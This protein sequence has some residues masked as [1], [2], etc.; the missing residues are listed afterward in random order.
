VFLKI[1]LF[2]GATAVAAPSF[3]LSTRYHADTTYLNTV[4]G[5][6][7]LNYP[8]SDALE[9]GAGTRATVSRS[10][11]EAIEYK[12][13]IAVPF[14]GFLRPSVRLQQDYRLA[15][16][17]SV[18][19]L[20]FALQFEARPFAGVRLFV[21]PAWYKRFTHLNKVVFLPIL[22]NSYTEHDFAGAIGLEVE[23]TDWRF[24]AEAATFEEISVYNLNNPFAEI[25][26]GHPIAGI[27]WS[28]FSRYQI[29]LGFGRLD[30]L[31]FGLG[32][33]LGI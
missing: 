31:S 21:T 5:A 10:D 3:D 33:H 22:R 27:D 18:S 9:F 23:T 8:L 16:T 4:D 19:H 6:A 11:L 17:L 30:R 29:L 24:L 28:L 1:F 15:D 25:R 13:E 7:L 14:A 26:V 20:L 2:L 32:L 12:A